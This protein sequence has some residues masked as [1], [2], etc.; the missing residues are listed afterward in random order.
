MTPEKLLEPSIQQIGQTLSRFSKSSTPSILSQRW[1]NDLLMDWGMRDEDFKVQLFR[2]VDV[3]PT[4]KTDEQ[5][6]RL[7][8]EYFGGT[9]ILPRPLKW[10]LHKLPT[11]WVGSYV[12]AAVL[13]HQF[14]RMAQTFMAGDSMKNAMPVLGSLW[15]KGRCASVDL[16]GEATVSESEADAYCDRCLEA[17]QVYHDQAQ[18]WPS[19]PLLEQDHHGPIPRVNLSI[20]ISALYSQ[21]D[22]ADPHGSFQGV[23]SRLRHILDLAVRLPAAITFDMEHYEL[24]D[25]TYEIFMRIFS[26]PAFQ[27]Y[28]YAGIALQTYLRDADLTLDRL[29]DWV[30]QRHTPIAI[31]L[32]KGAYWDAENIQNQQRGWPIPVLRHKVETDANFEYLTRKL[33]AH[34]IL[35][36]PAFGTHNL[37]SLA[38]AEAMAQSLHYPAQ[39][40]EFQSL[41]GMADDLQGAVVKYQRRVRV[42]TPVGELIPGMAYLVRRLLE[43]TSN[44]S[45]ISKQRH[46]ETPLEVLLAPPHSHSA[47]ESESWGH[48]PAIPS[49]SS[50]TFSN[51]PHSDFSR[52][53]SRKAMTE[54]IEFVKGQLGRTLSFSKPPTLLELKEELIST[55]PSRPQEIIARIPCYNPSDLDPVIQRAQESWTSWRNTS[56]DSRADILCRVAELM[57]HRRFELAAW[58]IFETGKPWREADGDIAEAIDFLEFYAMHMRRLGRPKRLGQ[59]PGELNHLEW[60]PRGLA[61]IIS[62]WNF[63]LAIPTGMVSAALVTGNV[64]LFKP[65]ERS[66]MMGYHLYQLYKEAGLPE[67]I[68]QF[69]P[70]GPE[71]GKALVAHSDIHTIAFTGSKDAGLHILQESSTVQPWQ[72]HV[73]HAIA[74]MGGKN[75]II[76]DE[77]ADLDEAVTGVLASFTGYQGQKCSACSRAIV[78]EPIYEEFAQRLTQAAQ[79]LHIGPPEDPT[80]HMGPMI[81]QRALDKVR[82]YV[83][84]AQEEGTILLDQQITGEGWF[85]GPV[86]ASNIL[87]HHRLAQEEIFGPVVALLRSSTFEEALTMAMQSDFALT[88]GIYSRSPA[89]IQRARETFDVGNLYIN[90]PITGSLVGRQPFGGHRLSGV[91]K[92]A[93]GEEYLTQFMVER[94]T[95]ENTLRRGFAPTE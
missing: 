23:A 76:I 33:L 85:Q 67:G 30:Q 9:P 13:R 16:L 19:R 78:L 56:P 50:P 6:T 27:N 84:I 61:L 24:K 94:V 14:T 60:L 39:H 55:N 46:Q 41:Y 1:W 28:P 58:E 75:A 47:G 91:G 63:S 11:S 80:N 32:V 95:C 18:H 83:H 87:P 62:P 70:G 64:V 38:H 40:Y 88:G 22:P 71:V 17:L 29:V 42:Y 26:E 72:H 48:T 36:R 21:L 20:K 81:D 37:R 65:S 68:L 49:D 5:F 74:E 10:S 44:E 43:N 86:I 35:F 12:G 51:E 73:K 66:P 25:L 57:R 3:L 52:D 69:L 79:S 15:K 31:R 89:N 54:A 77:S 53:L 8:A 93:G 34:P 45:F 59:E 82:E 90:R 7:L 4:L 92:K 2:F